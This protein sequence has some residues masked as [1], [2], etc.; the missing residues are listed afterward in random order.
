VKDFFGKV[1][2]G[3]IMAQLF[4]GAVAVLS[5]FFL[6]M[7]VTSN[8]PDSLLISMRSIIIS[9]SALSITA[10]LFLAGFCIGAGMLIHGIHWSVVGYYENK[11]G[12]AIFD[13]FWHKKRLIWQ[14]L[15]GPPKI[16]GETSIMFWDVRDIRGAGVSE[17]VPKIHKDLFPH[18]EFLQEFYL[19]FAQFFAHTAYALVISFLSVVSF[20]VANDFT[21]RRLVVGF[22]VYVACGVFFVLGRLQLR[23]LFAAE[24]ELATRSQWQ[25]IGI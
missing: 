4:P 23:S 15:L 17:N 9:W 20:I 3:F 2:F 16:V 1:T 19:Y 12:K 21:L 24:E 13:S 6:Y 7:T 5:A 18:F 11:T 10:Q 8:Q 14:V 25:S 22:A